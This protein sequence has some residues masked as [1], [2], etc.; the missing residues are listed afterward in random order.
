MD[1]NLFDDFGCGVPQHGIYQSKLAREEERGI[2]DATSAIRCCRCLEIP[3]RCA[4]PICG[5]SENL[6][7][8]SEMLIFAHTKLG[9]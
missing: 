6:G 2:G 1:I 8:S 9:G 5:A 7:G 4:T 3:Q